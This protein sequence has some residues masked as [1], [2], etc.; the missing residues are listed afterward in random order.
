MALTKLDKP[1]SIWRQIDI[2]LCPV[3]SLPYMLVGNTG[4]DNLMRLLRLRAKNR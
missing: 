1:E 3:E 4:D 2:R